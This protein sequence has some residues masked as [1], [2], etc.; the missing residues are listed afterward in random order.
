M[1][2]TSLQEIIRRLKIARWNGR[3]SEVCRQIVADSL[4]D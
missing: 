3:E 4:E 1:R 2:K